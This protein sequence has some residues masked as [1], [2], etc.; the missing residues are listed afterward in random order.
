[1]AGCYDRPPA[2]PRGKRVAT[3]LD[4]AI[5][6]GGFA[7]NLL[8]RQLRRS[9]PE[10]SVGLFEKSTEQSYKVG[11]STVEIASHYLIRRQGLSR[12]LYENQLPKNGLRYFFDDADR[13]CE[14]EEMSEAGTVN[15]PFHPAFQI[16][17]A[18]IER[19]L[20]DM[21]RADGVR[22]STGV[23]VGNVDLGEEGA[24]HAFDASDDDRT[25]RVRCRWL[26]DATGRTGL[27]ARRNELRKRE[28]VHHVGSV[29]GRFEGV[30]DVDTLGSDAF[31]SR[32]RY[33]H[34]ELS[35][36][37]FCYPG[38][39]IWF[40]PIR[41]GVTS[42]GVVGE[43]A[44]RDRSLRTPEGFRAFLDEHRAAASLLAP[45]KGI[46]VGS[47]TQIAFGTKRFFHPDRWGLVGEAASAAD[48]L[49]SPGSDFIALENDFLADMIR[50]DIAGE[51]ASEL[52]TRCDLYD[53]FMAARHEAAM[54]LYRNQYGMLGSYD[55]MRM[56]WDFDVGCYYNLW[57]SPYM[58]DQHLDLR[59]LR[60]QLRQMPFIHRALHNF[61]D[62]FG[63]A[64][65]A[66]RQRGEYHR[67]NRGQFYHGLTN[68]DFAEDVGTP[69]SRREVLEKTEQ[70]FNIVRSQALSLIGDG[71]GSE[72]NDK[73]PLTAF[74]GEQPLA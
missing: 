7:G 24:S 9:A 33:T 6:G 72:K 46:D 5:L 12:Y 45:A 65:S 48:P 71:A 62:L 66:L 54:L 14:I 67:G 41:N 49:Y 58:L 51:S 22:V 16:D 43:L 59:Y 32:V 10:L 8:A 40:I 26:V 37:H 20:L 1:M 74:V 23:R 34:R 44:L 27:I 60:R 13:S 28:P 11:E 36:V 18:R 53:R 69:R 39:W 3:E 73:L 17:R 30:A 19:D 2:E 55:L 61:A 50:R 29:W 63:K 42:V 68:I 35:T 38:Y 57:L 21:N 56:K 31:R 15:L 25:T 64:E 70:I 4:V 47:F 52:A